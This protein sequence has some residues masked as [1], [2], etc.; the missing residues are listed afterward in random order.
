MKRLLL[1][2]TAFFGLA[3]GSVACATP[4]D[5]TYTGSLV[6]FM[7]PA[8]GSY[9]IIAYGAQGGSVS[10]TTANGVPY[11]SLG[12]QGAEIGGDFILS[13]GEV[14]QIAVGGAGVATLAGALGGG[15]G[16]AGGSFVV[17]PGN[18]PLV[19][20]GGGGGG[21][22][23]PDGPVPG[24]GGLT[25]QNG[26]GPDCPFGCGGTDAMV[27]PAAV[28]TIVAAVVADFLVPAAVALSV[29]AAVVRGPTSAAV[30]A[31]AVAAVASAAA[32]AAS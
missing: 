15:A 24:Q 28:K 26:G 11:V 7:V 19:I 21:G 30:P 17:G 5:F 16:G 6:D 14:L 4:I 9:Q 2:G 8:A 13:Q 27:V 29:V 3:S 22:L 32:V 20:A 10:G 18:T 25:G 31:S 23:S 12:G 1:A